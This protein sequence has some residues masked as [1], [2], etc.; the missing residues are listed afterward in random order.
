MKVKCWLEL[1]SNSLQTQLVT[2]S[3]VPGCI[4]ETV[5]IKIFQPWSKIYFGRKDKLGIPLTASSS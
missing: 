4:V 3:P 5:V 1:V 2:V